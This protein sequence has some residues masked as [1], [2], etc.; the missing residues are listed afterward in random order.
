MRPAKKLSV[1]YEGELVLPRPREEVFEFFSDARNLQA[2]TPPWLHFS[3]LTPCPVRMCVGALIDYKLRVH[4]VPVRWQTEITAWE[5]PVRFVDEQRRGPYRLWIH[6]HLFEAN[7]RGTRAIDLV[8]YTV[9]GGKLID[10]FF[11][12]RDVR[13]IFA[14]RGQR[15]REIFMAGS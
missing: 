1:C 9:P 3:I 7:E 14:Y 13:R 11:V 15:L 6:E 5:P 12:A 4:G 8:R 10:R 2:I